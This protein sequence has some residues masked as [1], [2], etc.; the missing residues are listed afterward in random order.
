MKTFVIGLLIFCAALAAAA[1]IP[2]PQS[3][4]P[5]TLAPQPEPPVPAV[6]SPASTSTPRGVVEEVIPESYWTASGLIVKS[7]WDEARNVL[8][9]SIAKEPDNYHLHKLL[10]ELDWYFYAD[11]THAPSDLISAAKEATTAM[12]LSLAKG[13]VDY[14]LASDAADLLGRTGDVSSI[15][16]LFTEALARDQSYGIYLAYAHGLALAND[17]RAEEFFKEAVAHESDGAPN[18]KAQYVEWLLRRDRNSDVLALT[19]SGDA[20]LAYLSFLRGVALER[21]GRI[22]EAR[23]AY[24]AYAPYSHASPAP[25]DFQIPGSSAQQ[26]SGVTFATSTAGGSKA[27]SLLNTLIPKAL[28]DTSGI[29]G[30]S[31]LVRGE[32]PYESQGG[33]RAEAWVVQLSSIVAPRSAISTAR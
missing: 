22:D 5:G 20:G 10:S 28:A 14:S 17:P 32:A 6:S 25:A 30:L 23:Q 1:E 4:V 19:D 24:A 21:L 15:D 11:R 7:E 2:A 12:E 16:E 26:Q 8:Q 13:T 27:Q 3:G 33:M 9:A 18:S 29:Q 31:Y